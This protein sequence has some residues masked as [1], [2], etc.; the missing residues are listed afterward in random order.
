MMPVGRCSARNGIGKR[1]QKKLKG[2]LLVIPSGHQFT[3]LQVGKLVGRVGIEPT[4][5]GLREG[6]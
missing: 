2:T 3:G 4:T 1:G 5:N 6:N